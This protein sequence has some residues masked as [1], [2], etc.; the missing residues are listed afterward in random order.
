MDGTSRK[1]TDTTKHGRAPRD[2]QDTRVG[3]NDQPEVSIEEV[4]Q[5]LRQRSIRQ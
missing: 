1:N 4:G 2:A 3:K 5:K